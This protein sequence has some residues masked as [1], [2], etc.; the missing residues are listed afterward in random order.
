MPIGG[1]GR[2][3]GT[4][5][6]SH[7]VMVGIKMRSPGLMSHEEV[8][9]T[10]MTIQEA[11]HKAV[12]GGYHIE[13]ADGAAIVYIG[14]NEEYSAWTRKDTDSSFMVPME[15]TFLDPQFWQA[16]GRALGWSDVCDLAIICRHGEEEC[17]R[18]RGYYWMYRWHCFIQ[19]IANGKTP[20]A[21][22]DSVQ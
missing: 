15:E 1:R 16:L 11:M 9:G 2:Y 21:F 8:K 12:E 7:I 17:S 13:S 19:E 14:A 4:P 3:A 22:F 10:E 18:C 6:V 20:E 5:H